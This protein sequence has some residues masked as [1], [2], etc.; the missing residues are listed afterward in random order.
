MCADV[1]VTARQA[2][3]TRRVLNCCC[4]P[5][6]KPVVLKVFTTH[7]ELNF[8]LSRFLEFGRYE[9][10]CAFRR[11]LYTRLPNMPARVSDAILEYLIPL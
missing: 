11:F 5:S 3:G 10:C 1:A 7:P 2:D 6:R 9:K 8:V 4:L